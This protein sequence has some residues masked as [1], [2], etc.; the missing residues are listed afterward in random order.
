[1]QKIEASELVL[2]SKNNVYHLDL[3]PEEI[4]NTVILVGDPGRIKLIESVMD[5]VDIRRTNREICTITGTYKGKRVSAI[6]TG[7][8]TDNTDI[9]V[10]ELDI[11]CNV[12]LNKKELKDTHKSLNLIRLGTC[13]AMQ[14]EVEIDNYVIS[15]YALGLDGMAY[16]YDIPEDVF[17]NTLSD[18]VK[19]HTDWSDSL[20]NIYAVKASKV[21]EEKFD[22]QKFYKGITLTA[23]GFYG[24]QGRA[25][26]LPLKYPKLNESFMS[27]NYKNYKIANYEM[28]TSALYAIGQSLGHNT[29]TACVAIANRATNKFSSNYENA[30]LNLIEY[31][32]NSI[33]E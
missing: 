12:D 20:P 27:F 6:S 31:T 15:E 10:T 4:A 5:S 18:A 2:N 9:V 11:L 25:I 21:L 22:D 33:L 19:K 32:F 30:M 26:R 3:S 23:P 29:L 1:M 16:F 28:E 14:P 8:G 7:M 17:V 13:G 24:A